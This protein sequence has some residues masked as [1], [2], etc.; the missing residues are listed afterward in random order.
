MYGFRCKLLVVSVVLSTGCGQDSNDNSLRA[1]HEQLTP[2]VQEM[3]RTSMVRNIS[4]TYVTM[5][6][7]TNRGDLEHV[8]VLAD[9]LLSMSQEIVTAIEQ[10]AD[11]TT[12]L[13]AFYQHMVAQA[14]SIAT[15]ARRNELAEVVEVT[16]R[17]KR[18]TCDGCHT[19]HQDSSR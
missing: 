17:L 10:N 15:S 12:P 8:P 4:P 19:S 11:S 14:E 5:W 9:R 6:Q 1:M 16:R 18:D 3:I 2:D 7:L 13:A